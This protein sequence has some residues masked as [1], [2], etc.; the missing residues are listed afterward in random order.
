MQIEY[1]KEQPT[2]ARTWFAKIAP[3]SEL[4]LLRHLEGCLLDIA[5]ASVQG[6]ELDRKLWEAATFS[7]REIWHKAQQHRNQANT[8]ISVLAGSISKIRNGGDLTAKQLQHIKTVL[9][10]LTIVR[11]DPAWDF[12]EV[13][14]YTKTGN[15]LQDLQN[16]LFTNA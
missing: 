10:V 5:E 16:R 6:T 1:R 12:V 14:E 8:L 11:G 7:N 13:T 15:T 4:E 9:D 3:K 2:T